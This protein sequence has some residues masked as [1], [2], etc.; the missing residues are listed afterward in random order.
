[1]ASIAVAGMW[2]L[3][4]VTA[5]CLASAGHTVVGID[6][7]PETVAGLTKARP[8][9]D[10]P[11]L[12][13]MIANQVAAGR[14]AFSPHLED[15]AKAEVVWIAYDTPVDQNDCA[16]VEFVYQRALRLTDHMKDGAVM[17]VSSQM[18]AGSVA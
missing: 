15:A 5:A 6:E 8:P 10:E 2:H 4:A 12:S 1:M 16:D 18:P 9:V 14:L 17:V 3:G 11:C 13:E 7:D